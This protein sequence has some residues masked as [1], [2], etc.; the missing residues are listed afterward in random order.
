MIIG[1]DKGHAIKGAVGAVGILNEVT[2]NRAVGNKLIAMLKEHGHT[3]VDCSVDECYDADT[4]LAGIVKKAN[5]QKLDLFVSIHFN[6][7]SKESANGTETYTTSTSGA[8]AVAKRI[9]DE[10]VASCGF[11]NRGLKEAS[12]YVLRNTSAPALLVEV[13][14]ITNAGDCNK[15]NA[16]KVAK[17]IFKGITG[18]A[19]TPKAPASNSSGTQF[20]VVAGWYA[21]RTNAVNQ[22]ANLKAKG[23]DSFLVAYTHNGTAGFRVVCG[24][25]A[26]R[27]NADN[28]KAKLEKAGFSAFLVAI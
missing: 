2:E 1:I 14:F 23:F 13:C 28:Q 20:R 6:S 5:A 26:N 16:D 21:N 11:Y 17:A 8:K 25:F 24:T 12:Y 10:V 3:V 7:F 9:N 22:Q 27:T 19:Y 15:Y 18:V 4:Q